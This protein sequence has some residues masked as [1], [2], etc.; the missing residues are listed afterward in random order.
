MA[1]DAIN[2]TPNLKDTV[3]EE[4]KYSVLGWTKVLIVI[5]TLNCSQ[6]ERE[7]FFEVK[8]LEWLW[9]KNQGTSSISRLVDD[10]TS[11]SAGLEPKL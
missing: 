11:G 4:N 5:Q 3:A 7:T 1:N 10:K 9:T 8:P 6:R 2:M